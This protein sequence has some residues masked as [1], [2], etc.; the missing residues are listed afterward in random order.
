MIVSVRDTQGSTMSSL[1]SQLQTRLKPK[2]EDSSR[3]SFV[4]RALKLT[5]R[6]RQ[7]RPPL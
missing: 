2:Y 1:L 5:L 3:Y 4:E 6:P 7:R